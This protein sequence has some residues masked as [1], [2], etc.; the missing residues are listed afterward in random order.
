MVATTIITSA[1]STVLILYLLLNE[2]Q[3]HME[4]VSTVVCVLGLLTKF[5]F[6]DRYFLKK[7]SWLGYIS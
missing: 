4:K 7:G 6:T 1:S 5:W 2:T 3:S